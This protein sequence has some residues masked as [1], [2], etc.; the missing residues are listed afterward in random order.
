MPKYFKNLKDFAAI[1]YLNFIYIINKISTESKKWHSV[2][3][4]YLEKH[5][6]CYSDF[7][8]LPVIYTNSIAMKEKKQDA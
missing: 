1:L 5:W 7:H 2:M 6:K 8:I 3:L 4:L